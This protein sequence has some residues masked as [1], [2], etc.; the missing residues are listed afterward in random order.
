MLNIQKRTYVST[1]NAS[2]ET[3]SR[4]SKASIIL[5]PF[6]FKAKHTS[7]LLYDTNKQFSVSVCS[8]FSFPEVFPQ[9]EVLFLFPKLI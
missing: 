6:T 4:G 2:P 5:I 7:F 1:R 3:I 8:V 9:L